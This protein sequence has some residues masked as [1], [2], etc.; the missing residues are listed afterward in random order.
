MS[1]SA[2]LH[3]CCDWRAIAHEISSRNH[4]NK[5]GSAY[6][7]IILFDVNVIVIV[8]EMTVG[9]Q[10]DRGHKRVV[11]L[12]FMNESS[13]RRENIAKNEKNIRVVFP[14]LGHKHV[15]DVFVFLV[16]FVVELLAIV[17]DLGQ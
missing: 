8:I 14:T 17:V 16:V 9:R 4:C 12:H 7:F 11:L 5:I 15:V 3:L 10:S 6:L 13:Q 2:A 1:N